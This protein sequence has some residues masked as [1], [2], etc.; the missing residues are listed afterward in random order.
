M[1]GTSGNFR[2]FFWQLLRHFSSAPSGIYW[3]A[4]VNGFPVLYC[5]VVSSRMLRD[6]LGTPGNFRQFH[7]QLQAFF[8]GNFRHLLAGYCKLISSAG[9]CGSAFWDTQ[10][11]ARNFRQFQAISSATSGIFSSAPSGTYWQAVINWFPV[12]NCVIVLLGCIGMCQELQA[13]S[14][15]FIGNFR[16]FSSA[17]AGIYWQAVVNQFPVLNCVVVSPRMLRDRL[18]ASGNF[19]Q[20]IGNFRHFSVSS[21]IY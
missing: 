10:A 11:C 2:Q 19:R 12:L 14:G 17:P 3:Q 20:F 9:T 18:G 4:V 21:G 13:T 8:I 7:R 5:V 1:P 15:N 6:V 16:H